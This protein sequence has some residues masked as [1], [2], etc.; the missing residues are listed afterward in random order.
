MSKKVENLLY[1]RASDC[2]DS[3]KLAIQAFEGFLQD[4]IAAAS[5]D[6][7][8]ARN[9]LRDAE[10][11]YR[12]AFKEAKRL[13]GP[14]PLYASAD[15]EKWRGEFLGQHKILAASQELEA[16]KTELLEDEYLNL[17]MSK[18]DIDR[19]LLKNFDAQRTG[20]R[21]LSN[22]KVRILLDKLNELFDEAQRLKKKAMDKF[23]STG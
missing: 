6:Y 5:P 4:S 15:F 21:K 23:Q 17:W 7:Y 12:E 2:F 19:L 8:R 14:P 22:I 1:F 16:V 18:E 10:K 11:F 9:Y 13:L 3:L 20:K